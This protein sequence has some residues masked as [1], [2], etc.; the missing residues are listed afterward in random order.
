[1]R[2]R[3]LPVLPPAQEMTVDTYTIY[4]VNQ[5]TDSMLFW[6]FLAP[7]HE[8]LGQPGF[9][10]SS[11][12]SLNVEPNYEGINCFVIPAQYVVGAGAG[13]DAVAPNA[14]IISDI[15]QNAN[16]NDTWAATYATVPPPQEPNLTKTQGSAPP[17]TIAIT[18]NNFDKVTNENNKWFS[19]QSFGLT[20]E[21]GFVGTTWSPTPEELISMRP[22]LTFY[23]AIGD[24]S[25]NS[26]A[27]WTDVTN[28][29]QD[30][31]VPDDFQDNECTVTYTADGGWTKDPG[32]SQIDILQSVSWDTEMPSDSGTRLTGT[33][34]VG[35]ALTAAFTC[36][37]LSGSTFSVDGATGATTVSFSY[38]GSLSV[39]K[40]KG[41]FQVHAALFFKAPKEE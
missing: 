9:F 6:C 34:T 2:V 11:S 23:V 32:K 26:L 24:F 14:Q 40:V 25:S 35:E 22:S 28:N 12:M 36:F 41:L 33:I 38:S 27:S 8:I 31:S 20:T 13:N 5:S 4:L 15:T 39:N 7:P 29:A 37:S 1:M 30:V 18:S 10:A 3:T 16:L 21:A 19:N 17:S